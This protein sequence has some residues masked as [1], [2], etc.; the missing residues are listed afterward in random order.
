M[1]ASKGGSGDVEIVFDRN[2]Y[3]GRPSPLIPSVVF[4]PGGRG[5]KSGEEVVVGSKAKSMINVKPRNV[6]YNAKRFIGRNWIEPSIKS[7]SSSH[8]F[9]VSENVMTNNNKNITL[10]GMNFVIDDTNRNI[11]LSP[12]QVGSH[13]LTHLLDILK[14]HLGHGQ[15]KN[16]VVAVPAKFNT[17]QRQAT[18]L[19]FKLA[20]L[21]V[22]RM[23]EEP[24]AA[25]LAYGLHRKPGV[26]HILVYDF[27]GG[28]LDVSVLHVSEGFVEVIGS[29]GDDLLGG[30]DFDVSVAEFI[31]DK[32]GEVFKSSVDDEDICYSNGDCH[33]KN[34]DNDSTAA[35]EV[36]YDSIGSTPF[37]TNAN[38]FPISEK[39]KIILSNSQNIATEQCLSLTN[40]EKVSLTITLDEYNKAVAPLLNRASQPIIDVL[41]E[42][43]LT[44]EDID[45]VVMVGGTSRMPQV[46]ELVKKTLDKGSLNTSIDPDITV[47]YGCASVID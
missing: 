4:Y 5:H 24:T 8:N 6:I 22:T 19:A 44:S 28:T 45:E 3:E 37:C 17:Q 23:L 38:L 40:N 46:R 21:K 41:E 9:Q 1:R 25:A 30:A 29:S 47:A 32:Y 10:S 31:K 7:Q 15:V 18:G 43:E 42:L 36:T 27:G 12:E 39:L 35:G 16:A 33:N 13:I 20:G 14:L 2:T 26:D 11:T 34:N